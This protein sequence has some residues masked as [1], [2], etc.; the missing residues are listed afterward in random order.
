LTC[1]DVYYS[2]K[3]TLPW[4]G[5]VGDQV[6]AAYPDIAE[7]A[8]QSRLFLARVVRFLVQEAGIGQFLDLGTG[9]PT[10]STTH[11]VAQG[12]NPAA[13]IVYVDNGHMMSGSMHDVKGSRTATPRMGQ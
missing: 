10:A 2:G 6:M 3:T 7:I 4:T 5:R 1:T 12:L 8:R 11:Q 9:L 13:R